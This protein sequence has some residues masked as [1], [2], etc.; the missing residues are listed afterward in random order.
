MSLSNK[1]AVV[2]GGATGIGLAITKALINAGA[3]V[4]IMGRNKSRLKK[5][6]DT[7]KNIHAVQVDVTDASSVEQAFKQASK[8]APISILVNNAGAAKAALFHKTSLEDWQSTINVNLTSVYLTTSAAFNDIKNTDHGRI[9]NI[10]STAGVEGC[11]YTSA[12]S[13][14]KHG[15]VGLTKSIALELGKT[16]MTVNAICPGFTNTDM[17]EQSIINVMDK[18]GRSREQALEGILISANQK[19]LVEPDEIADEV[20]KLCDEANDTINGQ[21]IVIDGK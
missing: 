3:T 17:V 19:R 21:A 7:N 13:A 2:T 6:A 11:A 8:T 4:T 15:V 12:Y 16:N 20:I 9:I 1:H 10:A 5:I 14:A 18:T